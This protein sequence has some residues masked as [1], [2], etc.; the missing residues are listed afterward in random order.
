MSTFR[1]STPPEIL[2]SAA[3]FSS[4]SRMESHLQ[5]MRT[6]LAA[7]FNPHPLIHTRKRILIRI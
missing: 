2:Q 1:F 7:D 4:P 6:P 5:Q 3:A